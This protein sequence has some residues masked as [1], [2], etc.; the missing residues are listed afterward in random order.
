MTNANGESASTGSDGDEGTN[1]IRYEKSE[2]GK[3]SFKTEKEMNDWLAQE[4]DKRANNIFKDKIR[5]DRKARQNYVSD[6][7]L[8]LLE[9]FKNPE[10]PKNGEDDDE[11]KGKKKNPAEPETKGKE[12]PMLAEILKK[13][14]NIENERTQDKVAATAERRESKLK[15]LGISDEYLKVARIAIESDLLPDDD[16]D[17]IAKDYLSK[18]PALVGKGNTA[19]RGGGQMQGAPAGTKGDDYATMKKIAEESRAGTG[20][21]I[22]K[23]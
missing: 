1:G 19:E 7:D 6:D 3:V 15:S 10:P 5:E 20:K 11:T 9:K 22:P 8:K 2:D 14:T 13:L 4:F 18:H 17:L 23:K 16:F 12:D 21:I